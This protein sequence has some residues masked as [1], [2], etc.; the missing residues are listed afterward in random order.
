MPKKID[1]GTIEGDVDVTVEP[2]EHD[3][4][5]KARLANEQRAK[6]IDDWK[7]VAVFAAVLFS[8]LGVGSLCVHTIWFNASPSPETLK[9]AQTVLTSLM[10]GGAGLLLGKAIGK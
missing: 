6:L 5:R 7:G 4:D 10:S 9:Y 3:D 2:R 8:V 1:L